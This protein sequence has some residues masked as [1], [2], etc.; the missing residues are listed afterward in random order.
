[1]ADDSGADS[2]AP[3]SNGPS[4]SLPPG[5]LFDL[6]SE[7]R[8]RHVVDCLAEHRTTMALADL[9]DEVA[10]REHDAPLTEIPAED[11]KQIYMSL[12]HNHVPKLANAGVVAYHQE[13]DMVLPVDN[14]DQAVSFLDSIDGE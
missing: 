3:Q 11:V 9:A 8:R 6:F 14:V 13:P 12:Y 1:M 7:E 4:E 5:T 2:G 10:T